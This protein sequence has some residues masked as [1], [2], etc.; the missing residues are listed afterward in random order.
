M[1]DPAQLV[2]PQQEVSIQSIIAQ[3]APGKE[4]E[5]AAGVLAQSLAGMSNE[6][7]LAL[8]EAAYREDPESNSVVL[9]EATRILGERGQGDQVKNK[10]RAI[11]SESWRGLLGEWL[12]GELYDI[13]SDQTHEEAL[14]E[15]GKE[16][17]KGAA[18]GSVDFLAGL[19]GLTAEGSEA[20]KKFATELSKT[21]ILE[22]NKFLESEA[23]Q[24]LV[25]RIS[26]WVDKNPGY[27]V[28]L[29][30]LAAAPAVRHHRHQVVP[31]D[32]C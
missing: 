7:L 14:M 18:E 2:D 29:A 19:D 10:M 12:G 21:A 8:L 20:V 3:D 31:L 26:R 25:G 6:D 1:S 13:I 9:Q 32:F 17:L 16:A 4:S 24:R 11:R 23:G 27:V 15:A 30:V 22:G 28:A 5:E